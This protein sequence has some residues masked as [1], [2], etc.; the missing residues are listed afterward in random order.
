MFRLV[1]SIEFS[2][3]SLLACALLTLSGQSGFGQTAP[4]KL[5]PPTRQLSRDIFEQLIDINTTDSVGSTTVAA[6]AMRQRLLDAGFAK[7]EVVVLGPNER[8]GNMVARLRGTGT[9]KPILLIGHLDVVEARR[10]D[11]TTDPFKFIEKDG[12]FY[13]R[14][15][16]DMKSGDAIMVTTF[17][18]MKKEG[19]KPDRDIILALTADE[20]GGKSNGVD[21][22]LKNHRDRIEADYVLNHDGGGVELKNGKALSVDVDASEKLYA[23][24][25]LVVT[26]PGGHSSLPVPDNAIY[27][28]AD[29]L[30]RLQGYKFPFELNPVTRAY[31]E[32]MSAVE[33]G[34][35]AADMK[36]ILQNPPDQ[37][38]AFQNAVGRL[39]QDPSHNSTM[40]TTCVA[41]RLEAGHANNAL[42]QKATANVNCRI[43][44]EHSREEIRQQL[45][46]VFADPKVTVNYVNDAGDIFPSAPDAKALPPAAINPGVMKA[47]HEVAGKFWPGVPIIPDMADGASDGVYTNA[48]GMPTYA[49]SGIAIET[50]DLRMHGKDERVPVESYFTGVDFFYQFLKTLT[51]PG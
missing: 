33:S 48:A 30:T 13:G 49:I 16:Q 32:T 45:I 51:T 10:E 20:E 4:S 15:T 23:D 21:W 43:L 28:L 50:N 44:P 37:A 19:Y 18:R 3:F 14:G 39:S 24:Y 29:A 34:Q 40:H 41:T 31:F 47:L 9:G 2:K 36:A 1:C 38:A 12:Y 42:P 22:L 35:T 11:W 7:D 8:K 5:D 25:Q 17:I 27:H 46:G 26:N 6:E